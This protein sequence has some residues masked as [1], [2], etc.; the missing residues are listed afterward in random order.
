MSFQQTM[1][2]SGKQ[3]TNNV[4]QF[5]VFSFFLIYNFLVLEIS[6]SNNFD[7]NTGGE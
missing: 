1:I 7:I 3:M 5:N 6:S 4:T 2:L